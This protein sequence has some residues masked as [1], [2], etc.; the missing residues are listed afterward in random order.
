MKRIGEK[1]DVREKKGWPAEVMWC[2]KV[3]RTQRLIDFWV[4]RSRWWATEEQRVYFR[5]GTNRGMLEVSSSNG[6]WVLSKMFD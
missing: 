3:Y 1:V 2:G 6:H 4:V 5:L